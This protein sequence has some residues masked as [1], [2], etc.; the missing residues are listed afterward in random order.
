MIPAGGFGQKNGISRAAKVAVL[1][2]TW[3]TASSASNIINKIVLNDFPYPLTVSF[4]QNIT[5]LLCLYPLIKILRIPKVSVTKHV[6]KW[7][8]LPLSFGKFFSTVSSHFSISKVAVS[9]AHTI[10]ASMPIWVLILGRCIW[11]ERQ[12]MQIYC[13]VIPIFVGIGMA[14]ISEINFDMLG[15]IS[16]FV[17]TIGFALQGLYTKKALRDLNINQHLLLQY[18]SI[19]GLLMMIPLW[20]Y[21]DFPSIVE[22]MANESDNSKSL[23]LFNIFIYLILSG[24]MAFIQGI[25]AFTVISLISTVSYSVANATKRIV[26]IV[27][28]ILTLKN[29]VTA[30]NFVGMMIACFGVFNYNRVKRGVQREMNRQLVHIPFEKNSLT[31]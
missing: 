26:V 30:Y 22:H 4:I 3:Y 20:L 14:T 13:S 19:Y 2:L 12:P 28:S 11:G 25:S 7:S 17:S 31:I 23:P 21:T 9:Y 16:A 18:L 8:I 29:P 1:C 5:T 10:K 6:L 27:V 15:T 24:F